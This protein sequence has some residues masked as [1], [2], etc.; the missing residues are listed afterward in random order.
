MNN[1]Y[2]KMNRAI[3][4]ILALLLGYAAAF[5]PCNSTHPYVLAGVCY[6]RSYNAN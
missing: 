3:I 4:A 6:L 1:N 2:Y 5:A